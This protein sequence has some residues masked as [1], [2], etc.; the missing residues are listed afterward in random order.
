MSKALPSWAGGGYF[1]PRENVCCQSAATAAGS[2]GL[3]FTSGVPAAYQLGLLSN[4]PSEDFGRLITLTFA[5]AY[6][7][8]FFA[9]PLRKFYILKQKLVFPGAVA[10]AHTIRALHGGPHAEANAKK[11]TRALIISFAFAITFRCVSEYAPG[12][13]WDWHWGWTLYSIGAQSA[14]DIENWNWVIE[15]TPAFFGIGMLS[16]INASWSFLLGA[17]IAWGIIGPTLVHYGTATGLPVPG[18]PGYMNYMNMVL[19][20][21]VNDPSPRYW[22]IWPGTMLLLC[23]S[24]S[25]IF[26]NYKAIYNSLKIACAPLLAR[27]RRSKKTVEVDE[28]AAIQDPCP[29]HEQVPLWMWTTGILIS[30]IFS[31]AILG[32]QYKQNVG[33]TLLA[34]VF[35]FIFSLIGTESSGRTN[36]IPVTTIGNA[37]QLVIGGATSGY[38]IK[39]AQLYN[40]T[41]GLLA[42]GASYQST[43]MVSDLKTTHLIG[44]SPRVQ[45]YAQCCGAVVSIF[46]S[47]G[48]Y[49]LFSTA[50]PCIN[51][52]SL[53]DHCSFP[54]PDVG[55][56]RAVAIAVTSP[57]LP[58][59]SSSAYF[60]LAIGIFA[61]VLT[62][63]K[64]RFIPASKHVYV[65][66][67]NAIGIAMILNTTTYPFAMAV[68]STVAYIWRKKVPGSFGMF[69]Y[70]VAA[71]FIAGEGLGGIVGAVLQV[72]KVSGNYYGSAIGCPGGVYCG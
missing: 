38:A 36:I 60:A 61:F 19:S 22:M 4:K 42:V 39:S 7:G 67:L 43:D 63:V 9:I 11:K 58:V 14:I 50:Y 44:A 3:I 62:F 51:D 52:L 28:T 24:F 57:S 17:Y 27:L 18:Y 59:P 21:P 34:V 12:I 20:D 5:A 69:G 56:W 64:Y 37:S 26:A 32:T 68:G 47:A 16:G 41:G 72:A 29:P 65:P 25:E 66:N 54:A 2:L 23:A 53:A 15:F 31:C 45:L 40:T 49:I 46:M 55:A 13:L 8:M 33:I 48:M 1:G 70:A 30:I 6:Y 71:G 35:A 10:A